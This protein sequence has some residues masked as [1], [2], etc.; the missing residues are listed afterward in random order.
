MI[1]LDIHE[2]FVTIFDTDEG[3]VTIPNSEDGRHVLEDFNL[4]PEDLLHD[5]MDV[6]GEEPTVEDPILEQL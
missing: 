6:F 2:D 4:I 5:V 3:V 1:D